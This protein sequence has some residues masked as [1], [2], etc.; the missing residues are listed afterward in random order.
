M[1]L[2]SHLCELSG[3]AADAPPGGGAP[4]G[5]EDPAGDGCAGI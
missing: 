1:L 3:A 2:T 5:G 4:G